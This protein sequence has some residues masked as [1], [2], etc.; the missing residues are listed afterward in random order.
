[1]ELQKSLLLGTVSLTLGLA[2]PAKANFSFSSYNFYRHNSPATKFHTTDYVNEDGSDAGKGVIAFQ[3]FV[4]EEASAIDLD[5]LNTRKLDAT[6]LDIDDDIEDLKIYFINEGAG[7][8]N[9]LEL[10]ITGATSTEGL[11]FNNASAG[12]GSEQLQLGD[13]VSV[14][15]VKA[16]STLDFSLLAN[17]YQNSSYYTYYAGVDRNPD[18]IQ[19]VMA[20]DYQGYLILAWEDLYG[21]GDKDYNDIVFAVDIGKNNLGNVP[22]DPISNE[23]PAAADDLVEM[24]DG[25]EI[26]IDVLANDS[27]PDGDAITLTEVD[28]FVGNGT[29]AIQGDKVYYSRTSSSAGNDTFNYTITDSKGATDTA[30][31]TIIMEETEEVTLYAD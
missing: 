10:K 7:F 21:G 1:M 2:V 12:N 30:T 28:G 27:D 4:R 22:E 29:V 8:R 14:G 31:V 6:E 3:Q 5:E 15:E 9:Q 23:S 25:T 24:L 17:G 20:Y 18:N 13:Y 11:I 26:T 16:G 19:H